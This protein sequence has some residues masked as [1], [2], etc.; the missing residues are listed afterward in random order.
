M[1]AGARPSASGDAHNANATASTL[2]LAL[3]RRHMKSWMNGAGDQ[4]PFT[5]PILPTPS[6]TSPNP[7]PPVVVKKRGRPRKNPRPEAVHGQHATGAS[8]VNDRTTTMPPVERL[9]PSNSTSPQLANIV[10]DHPRN[11]SHGN[12]DVT[13]FP[14]P[15]PSEED[16]HNN[17][18]QIQGLGT[19][20]PVNIDRLD[21]APIRSPNAPNSGPAATIRSPP[22]R[23]LP[24]P[25]R[26]AGDVSAPMEKRARIDTAQVP[27]RPPAVLSP[28]ELPTFPEFPTTTFNNSYA[29]QEPF[30][31]SGTKS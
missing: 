1:T 13:V 9:P 15:T 12:L 27:A 30:T 16:A 31:K 8:S 28:S 7:A 17:G 4:A 29:S 5:P 21:F 22:A 2:H 24:L 20:Q 23:Q 18:L 19:G 11:R 10:T 25:K 14:S 6:S 26:P 3:G